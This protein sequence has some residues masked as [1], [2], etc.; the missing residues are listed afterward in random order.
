MA[1]FKLEEAR[2]G[3]VNSVIHGT[4]S[5]D[6]P[7]GEVTPKNEAEEEALRQLVRDDLATV[8]KEDP[9]RDPEEETRKLAEAEARRAAR[10]KGTRRG[11]KDEES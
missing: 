4:I 11:A 8:T 5:Y 7:A 6:W 10:A 2:H 1:V 3:E 9:P